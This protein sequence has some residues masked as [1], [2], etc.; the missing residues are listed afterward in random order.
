MCEH[1]YHEI[2]DLDGVDH[3]GN[4]LITWAYRVGGRCLHCYFVVLGIHHSEYSY[5]HYGHNYDHDFRAMSP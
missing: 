4:K 2:C 3:P 5:Y 1:E